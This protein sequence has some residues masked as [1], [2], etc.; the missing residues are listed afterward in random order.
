MLLALDVGNTNT[1][2]GLY[3]GVELLADWRLSTDR[4]RTAD[5]LAVV[6]RDLFGFCNLTF[7][8]VDAFVFACVVPQLVFAIETLAVRYFKVQPLAVIPGVKMGMSIRYDDPREVGADRV[9]NAVAAF[10]RYGGPLIVVDFGT[11]T[12]F[13]AVSAAGEYL[14]GAIA[15]GIVIA[16]EALFE[17]AAKLTRVELVRPPAAIGKNT[18]ASTQSGIVFGYAGM[19]DGLVE[20]IRAELGGTAHVVATGGLADLVA[21][22]SRTI[23]RVDHMLTLEGLRIIYELNQSRPARDDA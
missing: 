9:V 20:R 10:R 13:D 21:S 8:V 12:T 19:V 3:R 23:E 11:A 5:E 16:A 6:L 15:P 17:H 2:V 7:D 1:V 22:V 18:V 4:N 14:G